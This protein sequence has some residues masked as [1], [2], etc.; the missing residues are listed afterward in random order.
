MS[1]LVFK[2][3]MSGVKYMIHRYSTNDGPLLYSAYQN[4]KN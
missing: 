3:L 4:S 1:I 2:V